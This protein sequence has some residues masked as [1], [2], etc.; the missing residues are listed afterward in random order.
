MILATHT[1]GTY[2]WTVVA[3]NTGLANDALVYAY[4]THAKQTPYAD[5]DLMR[6]AIADGDVNY[7]EVELG[8]VLRDGSPIPAS[9]ARADLDLMLTLDSLSN[10]FGA[11]SPTLRQRLFAACEHPNRA[12]WLNARSIVI[13][14]TTGTLWQYVLNHTDWRGPDDVPTREDIVTALRRADEGAD[15]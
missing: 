4:A 11:L 13:D 6:H 15:L 7:A 12:T 2:S 8:T 3:A 1:T 10:M 9:E 14:G 5:P